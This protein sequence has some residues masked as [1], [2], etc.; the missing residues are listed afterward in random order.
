MRPSPRRAASCMA[1]LPALVVF[2]FALLSA[3]RGAA[4]QSPTPP[5]EIRAFWVDAFNPGIKS[6][7]EIDT[8][9]ARLQ[10]ANCNTVF[11]Q[12]RKRGDAYYNSRYEPRALDNRNGFD[13]LRYLIEK[14]HAARPR[15]AVHA[16]I[17][18]MAVGSPAFDPG[19]I[20][21][22]NPAWRSVSET[23]EGDDKEAVKV[24]PGV[25]EASEWTYRVYMDVA[26]SYPVDGIHFDFIRYGGLKWGYA[27]A[28]VAR[29]N[30]RH[31]RQGTPAATDPLWQQ[32]RRDQVSA[33]VRRVY[34]NV[35]AIKPEMIVSAALISW[36]NGP[37]SSAD[38]EKSSAYS[39]VFQDW[40][41]WLNEGI[42]DLGCP[43]TYF[44]ASR[45]REFHQTW[46][47][48]IKEHQGKR[49]A[50]IGVGA[51]L[52]PLPDTL[53]LVRFNQQPSRTSGKRAAGT[54]LYSY[55]GTNAAK[56]P[57]GGE[58]V[59]AAAS[60]KEA[61][62]DAL[63]QVFE[64]QAPVPAF[65][66]KEQPTHGHIRGSLLAGTSLAWA[67]GAEV[68]VEGNNI[69]RT[70]TAGG[71]GAYAFIDLPPGRYTLTVTY[72]G[73]TTAPR[74]VA[75]T[76]GKIAVADFL[77]QS[78]DL[79][80]RRSVAGISQEPEGTRVLLEARTITV[81]MDVLGDRFYVVDRVGRAPLLVHAP[82]SLTLPLMRDDVVTLTG[83]IRREN[84][85]P[86]VAADAVQVVGSRP[87]H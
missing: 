77:M 26:R 81:G 24:D 48:W 61:V 5:P 57:Q 70:E 60:R 28:S 4:A 25:P 43:M 14:A 78:G 36:G 53:D 13:P 1:L 46:A 18:A 47:E 10:R 42:L 16:W 67:D 21:A 87:L 20:L 8:L 17:N 73:E 71:T 54:I 63:P 56:A 40:R 66:W 62:Y 35:I 83:I 64:G 30:R 69:R 76:A 9:I 51:W 2:I 58:P 41:G 52:N 7:E 79:P 82:P 65:P 12:V 49:A 59:D 74:R 23:G 22:K 85:R 50:T 45:N 37:R 80:P 55:A 31:G 86:I 44:E 32:W 27:P 75:V 3:P 84:G 68:V 19:H 6:R 15:I 38:W 72:E 39:A 11:A 33:L 34:A 29:F